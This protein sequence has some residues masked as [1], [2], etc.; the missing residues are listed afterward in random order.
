MVGWRPSVS[1]YSFILGEA[2]LSCWK[3]LMAAGGKGAKENEGRK[4]EKEG[5]K[6]RKL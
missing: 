3:I 2:E 1:W 4:G 5:R 6:E